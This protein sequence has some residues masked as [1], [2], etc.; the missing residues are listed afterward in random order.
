MLDRL[1]KWAKR[2]A[3]KDDLYCMVIVICMAFFLFA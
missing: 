1:K 3:T 2:P